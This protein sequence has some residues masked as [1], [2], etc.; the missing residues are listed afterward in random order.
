MT[1]LALTIPQA[2]EAAGVT[3]KQI[4]A[5]I[6]SGDLKAKRQTRQKDAKGNPTGEGVG[7]YLILV[8]DLE[9][10]LEGLPAA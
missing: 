9:E 1:R 5:W 7:K 4:R 10:C 3:E 8:R 2:A 6:G